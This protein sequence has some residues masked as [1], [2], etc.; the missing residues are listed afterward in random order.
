MSLA[1]PDAMKSLRK[2]EVGG[3]VHKLIAVDNSGMESEGHSHY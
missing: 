1:Q 2:K 3:G